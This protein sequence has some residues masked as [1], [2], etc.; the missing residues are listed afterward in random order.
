MRFI[1]LLFAIML[2]SC[3]SNKKNNVEEKINA[4]VI[5]PTAYNSTAP[6][7]MIPKAII[8]K[9]R[10]DYNQL[11]PITMN[12]A[13]NSIVS[14]PDPSDIND[15]QKP[16]LLDNGYLLDRRGISLNTV[17]TSFTYDEY[18][19]LTSLPTNSQL[20]NSIVDKYPF[21]EIYVLPI[22]INEANKDNCNEYVKNNFLNCNKIK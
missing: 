10:A 2:I 21:A 13:K 1:Y 18:S 15:Y 19:K 17:F 4:A 6:Q 12:E 20:I 8:Y 5:Q 14:Y 11:V 22:S 7:A 3:S 9:T 16:V